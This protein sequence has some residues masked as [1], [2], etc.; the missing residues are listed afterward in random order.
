[1]SDPL[2]IVERGYDAI[3]E[4]FANWGEATGSPQ[5]SFLAELTSRLPD[6]V[7]LLELGCGAGDDLAGFAERF[8]VTGVDLSREQLRRAEE[9]VPAARLIRA[10]V[11]S[12]ELEPASF[13]AVVSFYALGHVPRERHAT[14]YRLVASWLR[15]GGLFLTNMAV[16]DNP[17]SVDEWLGAPMFF[18]SWDAATNSRLVAEAGFELLRDEVVTMREPEGDATFQWVLARR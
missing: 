8:D 10:D 1:M 4:T 13:A 15:P 18:S 14:L 3:A 17:G 7:P 16:G 12:L 11:C 2:A 5:E 9:R 6:G